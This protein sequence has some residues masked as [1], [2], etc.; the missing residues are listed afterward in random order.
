MKRTS[1]A[2]GFLIALTTT[3]SHADEASQFNSGGFTCTDSGGGYVTETFSFTVDSSTL[4]LE[5]ERWFPFNGTDGLK[6]ANELVKSLKISLP[7]ENCIFK[8]ADVSHVELFICTTGVNKVDASIAKVDGTH[9]RIR[10][11]DNFFIEGIRQSKRTVSQSRD[12]DT[13]SVSVG[14]PD[15]SVG[16]STGSCRSF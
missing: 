1:F 10:L 8:P 5:I 13:Y 14:S 4:H 3:I 7:I 12:S 16:F 15:I 9:A 6:I 2:A 11:P